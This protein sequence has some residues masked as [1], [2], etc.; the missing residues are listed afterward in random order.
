MSKPRVA[1]IGCG[2]WG[3]NH[4]RVSHELGVLAAVCDSDSAVLASLSE[5]YPGL[6]T[7]SNPDELLG[8]EAID[9]LI[10]A[11]PAEHHYEIAAR[12][13]ELGKD[14]FIEK[15]ITVELEHAR[16]LVR[17]ADQHQR[18]LMV[19]HLLR[20]H[21]AYL[22]LRQ[23]VTTGALGRLLYISTTR[24]N[25]GRIRRNEN[26]FWSF[27]PHDI[28]M[29]LDIAGEMPDD[30][31]VSGGNYLHPTIADVTTSQLSFKSG[32]KA[33]IFVSWL[34]PTKEQRFIVVGDKGMAVFDDRQPWSHKLVLYGHQVTWENNVPIAQRAEG[35]PQALPELEPLGEE[36]KHFLHCVT[37]RET[38]RTDGREALRVL[39]VLDAGQRSLQQRP[40]KSDPDPAQ[41]A[42][43][44]PSSFVHESAYVDDG[45]TIGAG[46]KVWHF[47]HLLKNTVLGERV[48]VGQNAMIGPDVTVGD[49]CKIQNNVS[50]YKGVVLEDNVF[51]GPSAVFTNVMNPRA[52][53]ERKH[54]FR[55][56]R[57]GRGASL[58]ANCTIVC[59]NSIGSYAFVG[60]G[61][62]V[63]RDVPAY[64]LVV[65]SPARVI[66]WMCHCGERLT[67]APDSDGELRCE[68]CSARY[69]FSDS[70]RSTLEPANRS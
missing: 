44:E 6:R 57:V 8:D 2:P 26:A 63:T 28:S 31:I 61:A 25:F 30:V 12:A 69:R 15:P 49:G 14:L 46:S 65:G 54:E 68:Q 45:V 13:L 37:T 24:L 33:N 40:G 67:D 47:C 4:V 18:V 11:T 48:I 56:T 7:T 43:T 42:S 23:L 5:R 50:L 21:P 52:H 59:G 36:Q 58:G 51:V 20:Y 62:V 16:S 17:L 10:I 32:L 19:G 66:G 1:V 41:A 29:I 60:A 27:A 38:P 3:K 55:E 34:H 53:I 35:T 9:A 39:R 70:Q 64:A 22:A